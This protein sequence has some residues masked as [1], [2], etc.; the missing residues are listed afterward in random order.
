MSNFFE[1]VSKN[2]TQV[3][4]ELLGP[5]YKYYSKIKAPSEL[6]MSSRGSFGALSSNISGLINYAE[7]LV[8]GNSKASKTGGPLGPQFF[9]KTGQQCKAKDTGKMTTR[10]I[11]MDQKPNGNIPFIS[12]GL[13]TNFS[14]FRGLIP[15]TFGNLNALNPMAIFSSFTEGSN[16]ECQEL[17][18]ET[19]PTS[20]N[21]HQSKQSEYVTINDI[22]N[23]DACSFTL[24]GKRNPVTGNGCNEAFTNMKEI[25]DT[26]V[27]VK[28][29]YGSLGIFGLYLLCKFMEKNKN[30]K[31]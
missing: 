12:A 18:M 16:P 13:G 9:L 29:F 7:V 10:Y 8:T 20:I 24:S 21:N 5:N 23:M 14:E 4:E 2:A 26:D 1:D 11:Y 25:D 3:E 15:G 31:F 6:G 28:V 22:S 17:E 27:L 30:L 19:T